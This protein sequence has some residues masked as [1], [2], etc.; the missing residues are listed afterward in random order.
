MADWGFAQSEHTDPYSNDTE[1]GVT[2]TGGNAITDSYTVKQISEYKF[3]DKFV[4]GTGDFFYADSRDP[5]TNQTVVTAFKWDVGARLEKRTPIGPLAGSPFVAYLLQ[6]DIETGY[7]RQ[8]NADAG[9][10]WILLQDKN[11]QLFSE[12]GYRYTQQD[13]TDGTKNRIYA[14]RIYFEAVRPI[15]SRSSFRAW[16]EYMPCLYAWTNW[17]LNAEASVTSA[18]DDTF[19]LKAAYDWY[20]MS[21]PVSGKIALDTQFTTSI[22]AKF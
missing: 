8:H 10:H 3:E 15:A 22:V 17:R 4:R 19:S 9:T 14:A 7:L 16:V 6:S 20:Y 12:L 1:V 18:I 5:N 21:P 2:T 11:I 13:N